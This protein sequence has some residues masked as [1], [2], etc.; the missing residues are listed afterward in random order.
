MNDGI[1][2]RLPIAEYITS[3]DLKYGFWQFPLDTNWR[4]KTALT[5][6]GCPIYEFVVILFSLTNAPCVRYVLNFLD[7]MMSS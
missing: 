3:L 2:S 5:V 6:P 1:L 7:G 4:D